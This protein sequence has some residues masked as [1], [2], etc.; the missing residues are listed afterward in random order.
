MNPRLNPYRAA[1]EAMK[2]LVGLENHVLQS[3]L[4][5]VHPTHWK[6]AT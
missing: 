3:G 5:A 2:A 1:P 4:G 6:G